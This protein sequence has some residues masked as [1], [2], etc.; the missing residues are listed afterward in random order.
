MI[1]FCY[2]TRYNCGLDDLYHF[3]Q[4]FQK[5]YLVLVEKNLIQ[6]ESYKPKELQNV[7]NF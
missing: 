2:T 4:I 3:L 7:K 5:S 6:V 1:F